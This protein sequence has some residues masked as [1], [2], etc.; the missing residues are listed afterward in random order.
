MVTQTSNDGR[1]V[2][3]VDDYALNGNS[4]KQTGAADALNDDGRR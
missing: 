1:K 2:I 4:Q 3:K